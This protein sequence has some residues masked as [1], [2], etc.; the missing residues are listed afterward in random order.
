MNST[1]TSVDEPGKVEE[2]LPFPVSG[3]QFSKGAFSFTDG[4]GIQPRP[5]TEGILRQGG[6]VRSTDNNAGIGVLA[7]DGTA[8]GLHTSSIG[9]KTRQPED[10][11]IQPSQH[12]HDL[13]P[14]K[15]V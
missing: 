15:G 12:G 4:H 14:G 1:S 13:F 3:G 11:G 8:Y 6:D 2:G 9:R 7:P 5:M 10:V